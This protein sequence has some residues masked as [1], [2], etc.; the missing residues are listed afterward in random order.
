MKKFE[1]NANNKRW[2][3]KYWGTCSS[4][5]HVVV[6]WPPLG[7]KMGTVGVGEANDTIY[8]RCAML[9]LIF[10]APKLWLRRVQNNGKKEQKMKNWVLQKN[11]FHFCV[12][13][14]WKWFWGLIWV[15]KMVWS[16]CARKNQHLI[17]KYTLNI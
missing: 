14:S 2:K 7:I 9:K 16:R 12:F 8:G 1:N 6:F 11:L 5:P 4:C 17:N 3:W 10:W 15:E 13:T